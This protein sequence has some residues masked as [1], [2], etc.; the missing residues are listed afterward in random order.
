MKSITLSFLENSHTYI[1]TH[2]KLLANGNSSIFSVSYTNNLQHHFAWER[3]HFSIFHFLFCFLFQAFFFFFLFYFI[4]IF[5]LLAIMCSKWICEHLRE[6]IKKKDM[7]D[8]A[9]SWIIELLLMRSHKGKRRKTKN[10]HFF[11]QIYQ[12]FSHCFVFH[13]RFA[14]RQHTWLIIN[15][16][17]KGPI[18]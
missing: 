9:I 17:S 13:C 15:G 7:T 1:R 2:V 8:E 3:F 16:T 6:K 14:L 4:T 18:I 12:I 11:F 10:K 5:F